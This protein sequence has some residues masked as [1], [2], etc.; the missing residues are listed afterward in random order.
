MSSRSTAAACRRPR[1]STAGASSVR[2]DGTPALA[3]DPRDR[4]HY[5]TNEG[6]RVSRIY[7]PCATS[8]PGAAR[9][10]GAASASPPSR[11]TRGLGPLDLRTAPIVSRHC[12]RRSWAAAE[13]I[14]RRRA[15]KFNNATGYR[16]AFLGTG[17][18]V[19][20]PSMTSEVEREVAPLKDSTQDRTQVRPLQ[21][22]DQPR[23]AHRLLRRRQHRRRA[24]LGRG[25]RR[26]APAR[27][28]WSFDPRMHEEF[29]PDDVI[30]SS[31]MQRGHL[32]KRE[33]AMWGSDGDA[34]RRPTSTRSPSPTPR[35]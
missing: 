25:G 21:L 20:L 17:F 35:P 1:M 14:T 34:K 7:A 22:E 27:P 26:P 33:D 4:I 13:E 15:A 29:Q 30:F 31:A 10:G 5:I 8:R 3:S 32:Y 19:P 16:P 6:T 9:R 2:H 12:R 24:T 11:A 18:R 23:T 28:Q